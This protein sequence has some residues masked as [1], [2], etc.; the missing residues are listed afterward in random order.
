MATKK[1]SVP[2]WSQSILAKAIGL[3]P[4]NVA[5]EHE[6]DKCIVFLQYMPHIVVTVGKIDGTTIIQKEERYDH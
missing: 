2:N 4:E 3:D 1:F 6:D 5:V